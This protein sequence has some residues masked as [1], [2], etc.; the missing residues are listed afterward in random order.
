MPHS[1]SRKHITKRTPQTE[2]EGFQD[3]PRVIGEEEKRQLILAHA[4]AARG[5]KDPVQR[6]TAWMGFFAVIAALIWGWWNTVG[7]GIQARVTEGTS[8]YQQMT[9]DM[10]TFTNRLQQQASLQAPTVPQ[11]T[12][13]ANAGSFSDLMKSVLQDDGSEKPVRDDLIAPGVVSLNGATGTSMPDPIPLAAPVIDPN[14]PGLK[15]DQ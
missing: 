12:N 11:P 5:V 9:E 1:H 3:T 6:V 8:A 13:A 14:M 4:A 7:A 10:N 2:S 15:L